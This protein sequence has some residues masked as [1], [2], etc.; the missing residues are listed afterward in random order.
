MPLSRA[1]SSTPLAT[2]VKNGFDASSMR[3]AIVRLRPARRCRP[4]SLR[5]K[6]NSTIARWTLRRVASLTD[7]GRL[8]TFDTVPTETPAR[9]ATSLIPVAAALTWSSASESTPTGAH[10]TSEVPCS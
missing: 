2:S 4:A 6:P 9:F 1:I 3:Y 5:M 10:A 7:S 8:R